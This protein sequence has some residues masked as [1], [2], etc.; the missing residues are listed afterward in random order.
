MIRA[1]LIFCT[2]IG[3]WQGVIWLTAL[4]PFL[5]P[6]PRAVAGALW[7]HRAELGAASLRTGAETI[8]GFALGAVIGIG[9]ALL[10]A[11]SAFV[12]RWIRPVVVISQTIPIF[13]LAP[14]LTLWL[15]YGMAPKL[16]VVALISFFPIAGALYDGL[17]RVP[18]ARL[19]LA[20]V[21]GA[22]GGVTLF[23]I[24]L[25]SALPDLASGLRLAAVL[26]PVGAVIGEW[27]GGSQGLG[28]VMLHANGRMRID[29]V[30]A[31]LA[32]VVALSLAFQ[33]LVSR[34]LAA[35]LERFAG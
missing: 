19:D 33:A 34:G 28:A 9:L 18:A 14:I 4:P 6:A 15:G 31:S 16:A 2:L 21:M 29:L 12:A 8:L 7:S 30:F 27:V 32:L 5:L 1:A 3:I 11:A 25:P 23:R 13:A 10:M 24:R 20:Q 35:R 22:G 17:Q 26:A